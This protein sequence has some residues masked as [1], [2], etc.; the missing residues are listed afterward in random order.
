MAIISSSSGN[1]IISAVKNWH[2]P[3]KAASTF[4]IP[5]TL[6]LDAQQN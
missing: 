5:L 4:A 2:I 6:W 3:V 1:W